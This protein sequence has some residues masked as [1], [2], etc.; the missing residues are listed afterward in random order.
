ML[1]VSN[2]GRSGMLLRVLVY[3][4]QP[5]LSPYTHTP[6]GSKCQVLRLINSSSIG[7]GKNFMTLLHH[8]LQFLKH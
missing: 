5:S 4:K 6:Q 8:I 3:T 7:F 1:L 2:W